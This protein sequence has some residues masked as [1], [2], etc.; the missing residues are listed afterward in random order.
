[1]LVDESKVRAED[2]RS[3]LLES[4]D[5][6]TANDTQVTAAIS[7]FV[8]FITTLLAA[9]IFTSPMAL[10]VRLDQ[11]LDRRIGAGEQAIMSSQDITSTLHDEE[12]S[13]KDMIEKLERARD[14]LE[15]G[16]ERDGG[17]L[18]ENQNDKESLEG[19]ADSGRLQS[20]GKDLQ[21]S[22]DHLGSTREEVNNQLSMIQ[23]AQEDMQARLA[24]LK[25]LRSEEEQKLS[26]L[27]KELDEITRQRIEWEN[28]TAWGKIK[29]WISWLFGQNS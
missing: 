7:S 19:E 17:R 22:I 8:A 12:C 20:Q 29:G 25:A 24:E 21:Q 26:K 6:S 15:G 28:K 23:K 13:T 3:K 11:H 27:R 16:V 18:R 9:L 2:S 4:V 10:V 14:R 5:M 1:M